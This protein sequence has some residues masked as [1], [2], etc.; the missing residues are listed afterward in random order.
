MVSVS[1]SNEIQQSIN[2]AKPR[3]SLGLFGLAAY[4]DYRS[5]KEESAREVR[6]S[7]IFRIRI[8][9]MG[10]LSSLWGSIIRREGK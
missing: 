4:A 7:T 3:V 2:S 1:F 5:L 8:I 6:K 9:V 10:T